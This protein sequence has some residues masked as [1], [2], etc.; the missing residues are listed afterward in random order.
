MNSRT[1]IASTSKPRR[2]ASAASAQSMQSPPRCVTGPGKP[3]RAP[4]PTRSAGTCR[5]AAV[6]GSARRA[7]RAQAVLGDEPARRVASC[8]PPTGPTSTSS[9][10]T[11][12][13]RSR[14]ADAI[15]AILRGRS[16][17]SRATSSSSR[18]PLLHRRRDPTTPTRRRRPRA[19][20]LVAR[21][22]AT[23]SILDALAAL[24]RRSRMLSWHYRSRD[25][26]LIAFSNAPHLRPWRS[27]PSPAW[28]ATSASAT[29]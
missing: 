14:P 18:R 24:H 22:R 8:C 12:P 26:R 5:A 20:D 29:C 21:R 27:P 16:S 4:R 11:R 28:T 19:D 10:S 17:S 3:D 2:S 15:P 13:A 6:R 1:P 7:A 25:E 9:S 23:K